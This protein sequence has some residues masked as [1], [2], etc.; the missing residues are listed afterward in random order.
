LGGLFAAYRTVSRNNYLES[1]Y[2][3]LAAKVLWAQAIEATAM[4][5]LIAIVAL[6]IGL[7]S[8]PV[9]RI[10]TRSW[11]YGLAG[12]V[13]APVLLAVLAAIAYYVNKRFLPGIWQWQSMVANIGFA[14]TGFIVWLLATKKT[15]PLLERAAL[16]S[17]VSLC[18]VLLLVGFSRVPMFFAATGERDAAKPMANVL[19]IM[20]DTLRPDHMSVYGYDRPT[21]PNIDALAQDA[22]VFNNAFAQA[23]WTKPSVGSLFTGLYPRQHGVASADWT[24]GGNDATARVDTLPPAVTTIAEVL[25]NIGY[26]TFAVGSNHHLVKKM[27]FSQ[28]FDSYRLDLDEDEYGTRSAETNDLFFQWFRSNKDD[29]F[30]A[31]LHYLDV[32][33]PF[34]SPPPYRGMYANGSPSIDYNR[35]KF[36]A[37]FNASDSRLS[38]DDLQHMLD[39][40]DEGI[41]YV[42]F[43]IGE[44]I[45][46]LKRSGLYED[47]MIVV[48]SD[49]GEEFTERGKLG[50]GQSLYDELLHVPLIVKYPCEISGCRGIRV[51]TVVELI[52]VMPTILQVVGA[53]MPAETLAEALPDDDWSRTGS[54]AISEMGNAISFR[55]SGQKLI[56]A[57]EGE[58]YYDLVNDPGE[59]DVIGGDAPVLAELRE[60]LIAAVDIMDESFSVEREIVEL[61]EESRRKLEALGYV[62]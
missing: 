25:S 61:D 17:V 10:V 4:G 47:A 14:I 19:I 55:T 26:A 41:A 35:R 7:L 38:P 48:V 59:L 28:G 21:T 46:D 6:V 20:I 37:E 32:H 27:G 36:G 24:G 22:T 42:D 60:H 16:R 39:S 2:D 40:Y 15:A 43:R 31:Y 49:H 1:G 5:A 11:R 58:Q 29:A 18:G 23:P 62:E 51:D 50:H 33:W 56:V 45:A 34:T 44:V 8:L 9:T 53:S 12:A 57:D 3:L 13:A 52:D 30:F 54:F